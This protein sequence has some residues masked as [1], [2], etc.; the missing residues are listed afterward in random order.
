MS[1]RVHIIGIAG[2]GM[3]G[4]ARLLVGQG[5]TVSGCDFGSFSVLEA[6]AES[7][8]EVSIEHGPQH[9]DGVDLLL[10][11]P[12]I[13]PTHPERLRAAEL[14]IASMD[15]ATFLAKLGSENRLIGV[16]G[17]HGK[18][19]ATSMLAWIMHESEFE[20]GRLLGAEVRGLGPNGQYGP[21]GL[22]VEV[23]E[24]F[25]TFSQVAPAALALLNIEADHLDYY[26][27][28][29]ALETA[30]QELTQRVTG[31][32]VYYNN[33]PG[34]RRVGDTLDG[35]V[36]VGAGGDWQIEG[37]ELD[38]H[39]AHFELV[40]GDRSIALSLQVTGR[41]NIANAAVVAVLAHKIGV[42][43]EAI[44]RGLSKFQGSP[45]RFEFRGV[46]RGMDIYEDY[47]H[48]PGE[49]EATLAAARDAGYERVGVVFQPH[50]ISRTKALATE[51]AAAL[52]SAAWVVVTDIYDAGEENAD[53][54][55][56]ELVAAPL[57]ELHGEVVYS[58]DMTTL[59]E[60]LSERSEVEAIFFLGAGDVA[61]TIRGLEN[62]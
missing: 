57:R 58:T 25:G 55:T 30:F 7:G 33:D 31:P 14:G 54:V 42:S 23:D 36:G 8:I 38:R 13:P 52:T 10:W 39:T 22:V 5:Y 51:L 61:Q 3:S 53:Q 45:R 19:T 9:L 27:N 62:E 46:H 40:S 59:W 21:D 48:L 6:L 2:A 56:G 28:I 11:S 29:Q 12:A 49:I 16:T 44:I 20:M 41:H 34:A 17:T 15:R 32:V 35:A 50:R 4:V 1:Q 18:T 43:D 47:A 26:G 60:S 24:S 37:I